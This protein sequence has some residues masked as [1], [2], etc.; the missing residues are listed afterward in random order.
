MVKVTVTTPVSVT[1]NGNVKKPNDVTVGQNG[2]RHLNHL[3]CSK[4][5]A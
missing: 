5:C 1:Y 2:L 4:R 3:A